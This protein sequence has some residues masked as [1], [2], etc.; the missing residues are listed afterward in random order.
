MSCVWPGSTRSG[1]GAIDVRVCQVGRVPGELGDREKLRA[2]DIG[3]VPV[4][5]LSP[6]RDKL[7]VGHDGD[8]HVVRVT[9]DDTPTFGFSFF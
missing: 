9:S 5:I 3:S 7:M 6:R 1:A 2:E 4:Q 8:F